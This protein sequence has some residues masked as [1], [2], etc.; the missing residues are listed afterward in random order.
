MDERVTMNPRIYGGKPV[1]SGTRIP[2]SVILNLLAHGYDVERVV[3]AYPDLTPEDV[4][5]ALS[6]AERHLPRLASQPVADAV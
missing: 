6:F 5:A 1:I 3:T 4:R 2:V